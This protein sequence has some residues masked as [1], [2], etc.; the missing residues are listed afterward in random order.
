MNF[1]FNWIATCFLC[2]TANAQA[3]MTLAWG[4]SLTTVP[5]VWYIHEA[6]TVT[7]AG[8]DGV[9]RKLLVAIDGKEININSRKARKDPIIERF[10]QTTANDMEVKV[11]DL[12]LDLASLIGQEPQRS[13][14]LKECIGSQ[15]ARM[16]Y[17]SWERNSRLPYQLCRV[18]V[19][20]CRFEE[21]QRRYAEL[22]P[23]R[24]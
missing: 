22:A 24:D 7:I 21:I 15:Y 18:W 9:H 16:R 5:S 6:D 4:D 20:E 11:R 23:T 12:E 17:C 19:L 2:F 8:C 3:Q 1:P 13:L 10:V 14:F